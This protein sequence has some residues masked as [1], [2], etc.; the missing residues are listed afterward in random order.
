MAQQLIK[1][2]YDIIFSAGG[3]VNQG[4][5]EACKE[6]NK[7]AIGVDMP[8]SHLSDIIITSAVKNVGAG[9]ELTIKDLVEGNFKGGEVVKY[10]LSNGGVGYEATEHLS[11]KVIK[12]VE[13]KINY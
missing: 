8:S 2:Q 10:D 1:D 5:W 12:F 11:N 6:L 13:D 7:M 3:G 9:L 4:V